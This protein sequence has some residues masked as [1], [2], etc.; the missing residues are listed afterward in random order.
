M[1]SRVYLVWLEWPERCFRV[2]ADALRC[3]KALVPA[4]SR[5]VRAR[6]EAS[7]LRQLPQATHAVVW[8]FRREWF[9]RAP[10]L[11]LL[12]TPGAGRELVSREA[13]PGVQ[14]H[15][16]HYHG[17]IMAES[18]AGFVLAWAR[19]FFRPELKRSGWQ[20]TALSD[21]LRTVAGSR[22]V[23]VGYGRVGGAIGAK[24]E[25]LGVRV[26]GF[27]RKNLKDL[28]TAAKTA[29]WLVLA[30]PSDTG[31]DDFLDA[32]LIRQ[33]PRQCVVINVGRGNSVDE[34]ALVAALAS[35]RL[36]GAYLDVFKGEPGPL[37]QIVK[38]RG[39]GGILGTDPKRLP[40]NLVRTPHASA[41]AADYLNRAFQ[42]LKDDG[43][44]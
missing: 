6:S 17:A 35:G 27:G 43:C 4:G 29:D 23:I 34:D 3:L 36:A 44:L 19:G 14:V 13:P 18:V 26:T 40:W 11:R 2:D 38:R 42:E 5:V 32:A 16:G 41:F 33:L 9:A 25:A 7:F 30:L 12:A 22:A 20:R 15:F 10:R 21:K 24:L 39:R 37:Q 8:H 28:P 31:T 1:A